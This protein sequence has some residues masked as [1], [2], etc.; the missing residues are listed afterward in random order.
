MR[1]FPLLRLCFSALALV[2]FLP[3]ASK[4]QDL[5][6]N[7]LMA[8]GQNVIVD[9]EG[10]FRDWIEIHN[11]GAN[12]VNLAG[13]RLTD[14]PDKLAK[15]TFPPQIVPAGGYLVVFASGKNRAQ[16]GSELHTNFSLKSGGEY[17]A[18]VR[19][20]GSLAH[21]V[22]YPVQIPDVSYEPAGERLFGTPTPRAA[23]TT[24]PLAI[25]TAPSFS[26]P[27][28]FQDGPFLMKLETPTAGA[29]IR[30][31]T[32]G[33]EPTETTGTRYTG[34]VLIMKTAVI[35]ACAFAAGSQPSPVVTRTYLFV[36]DVVKQSLD[37]KAPKDWPKKWGM[38]RVDYGLDP[39]IA[40]RAPYKKTLGDDLRTIPSLS[41]V[42]DLEG[43]FDPFE[44]IYANPQQKGREWERPMSL[45]LIEP[46]G[47]GGFQVNAGLRIRGG[48]S[49]DPG[50][51]KHSFR[52]LMRK[53]YGAPELKYPLFGPE[54]AQS[55][56]RFDIRCEQLVAWHYF[57]DPQADFLRDIFGRET[58]GALGQPYKRGD[59]HHLYINGQYWGLYQTDERITGEWGAE[60]FGGDEDDYDVVKYDAESSYG[61]GFTDGTLGTWRRLFEAGVRGFADDADYFA[62]QGLNPD[63]SRNR[64]QERLLDVDNLIDYMLAGIFITVDD[65]PPAFGTPN[66]WCAMRSRKEDFGF[67]FFA[68]DWEISMRDHT[69]D[70]VGPAPERSPFDEYATPESVNAWHY[71]QALRSNAEFRLRV[72]DHVQRHFFHGGPLTV[73][74]AQARWR[75]RM[76]EIDRAVVG[77]SARWGDARREGIHPWKRAFDFAAAWRE[78]LQPQ[79][80]K[81][82]DIIIID[83]PPRPDPGP[84]PQGPKKKPKPFTR[85]DW[86]AAANDRVLDGFLAGRSSVMLQHLRDGGLF[87]AVPAPEV[88][89]YG[90]ALPPGGLVTLTVEG[91]FA[92]AE[93]YYTID[94][95]DPRRIGGAVAGN[96]RR[97]TAPFA[98]AKSS[99]VKA[100]ARAGAEWSPLTEVQFT[101]GPDFRMLK[102]TEIFYHAPGSGSLA[103]DAEFLELKNTGNV[104]LDLTGARFTAGIDFIFPEGSIIAPGQFFV[105]A[106]SGAAFGSRY[107]GVVPNGIYGG[108]LNDDGETLTLVHANGARIFSINFHDE[109]PWPLAAADGFGFS[110]V[111]ANDRDPDRPA[112]W[113]ASA[114]AGGSPGSDD[115]APAAFPQVVVNELLTRPAA[116]QQKAVELLNTGTAPVDISG[117]WLTNDLAQPRKFR[118]PAGT[119]LQSRSCILFTAGQFG[120]ALDLPATGGAV[121]LVSADANGALTGYVHGL[122][123]SGSREGMSFGR[124][125]NSAGDER[126]PTLWVTSLGSVGKEQPLPPAIRINELHYFPAA[127]EEEF[128]ELQSSGE[129]SVPLAGAAI[130]GFGYVFPDGA[131]I[132][133]GDV[134]LVT[135]IEPQLFRTK[136]EIPASVQVFGPAAGVL[137]DDGER[138]ELRMP[139]TIDGV[140]TTYVA[141]SVRYDDQRPWATGAAGFGASLQRVR[142]MNYADE[143]QH[144]IAGRPTPG[145]VNNVNSPPRVQLVSPADGTTIVP[146]RT[147]DFTAE[148]SDLDGEIAKV[149]FLVDNVVVGEALPPSYRF[150]WHPTPGLHDLTARATDNEGGVSQ[151]GVITIDVDAPEFGS[152]LG[153][154]GEYFS[155]PELSG[156]AAQTR[157][158]ARIAFDWAERPPLPDFPRSGY[159]VRWTGAVLPK[160]SGDYVI[161]L[162]TSG[163]V[164]LYVNDEL[165][166]DQWDEPAGGRLTE[167]PVPVTF[168]GGELTSIRLEYAERDGFGNIALFWAEP[169]SYETMPLIQNQLY[170][171]TQDPDQ[172]GMVSFSEL[173]ARP[174]GRLFRTQLQAVNGAR[175]YLW[176]IIGDG[177]PAGVALTSGGVL[178]GTP[179]AAGVYQ[180]FVRVSDNVGHS[181]EKLLTLQV[182]DDAPKPLRPQLKITAPKQGE[183]FGGGVLTFTGTASAA[184]GLAELRYSVNGGPWHGFDAKQNWMVRLDDARGLQPGRNEVRFVA[185]DA[186]GRVSNAAQREIRRTVPAPLIVRVEGAGTVTPSFLGETQRVL[187]AEYTI[188]AKPQP[189]HLLQEWRGANGSEPKLRFMMSEGLEITAVFVPN[190]FADLS[191]SYVALLKGEVDEHRTRGAVM[192]TLT[193]TGSFTGTLDFGGKRHRFSGALGV[194]GGAFVQVLSGRKQFMGLYLQMNLDA[195]TIEAQAS[196]SQGEEYNQGSG[197]AARAGFDA[198]TGPNPFAHLYTMSISPLELRRDAEEPPPTTPEGHGYASLRIHADG[199]ARFAG[200]MSDGTLLKAGGLQRRDGQL[201]LYAPLY[202]SRGSLSGELQFGGRRDF[203]RGSGD[204]F[205]SRPGSN[206]AEG[207]DVPLESR[208]SPYTPPATGEP[209]ISISSGVLRIEGG[210][211]LEAISKRADVDAAGNLVFKPDEP[212][213]V[214]LKIDRASGL[215]TGSFLHPELGSRAIKGVVHQQGNR[216]L[217]YFPG[218]TTS[219]A[220]EVTQPP[221]Q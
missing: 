173:P 97:Y 130:S 85:T 210:D 138:V 197:I 89:P 143:P 133:P 109:A 141:D 9:E 156:E 105:L 165:V 76:E 176:A 200:R 4:A 221:A 131:E 196:F 35:R 81:A 30:F 162:R 71:W 172:L 11:P 80:V 72:A 119:V 104:P 203:G 62:V 205:W 47:G 54:G 90:G 42:M 160:V 204:L 3:C 53:E 115:A 34:P 7:E 103:E 139:I 82:D 88:A 206:E 167:I 83:P 92:G 169:G 12:A 142:T 179:T 211:L 192:L 124:I 1:S 121:W 127:G 32:D 78:G 26:P 148:A 39:R 214:R 213:K 174:V 101:P 95:S 161:F 18:L 135:T 112:S 184:R 116:G 28:G 40:D 52:V 65:S 63:G 6:I 122:T 215:V 15:W 107:P 157:N 136:Y 23:N 149:E 36:D 8:A 168:I 132:A 182:T 158:D 100:R 126:F 212:D 79:P 45:E 177:A 33:T 56:A 153:L 209:A 117:W 84:G 2:L 201:V 186:E 44:G 189:G 188:E 166:A 77:E 151:S 185:V 123:F 219:G 110:I 137:Q 134:V 94:G 146:P 21:A 118:I 48:A 5:A 24:E 25:A 198:A 29:V 207:L 181:A 147:I 67:R 220:V 180:F 128:V 191:G 102:L 140:N 58:Q 125:L 19:P 22:T 194:E 129:T 159:S 75:R 183:S 120:A 93:I 14:S 64:A 202:K 16:A 155:N 70:R 66:N 195:G 111:P 187:G 199:Q 218:N 144:W 175:P 178:S 190:P 73:E 46:Q 43:L 31:T 96:A 114:L 217:G 13:W 51:P 20:D 59:F 50:N 216:V 41:I 27:R 17:L 152:G 99:T 55:T 193:R 171:P 74:A 150:S 164:R 170:L 163:G 106:R 60:Y 49:R 69:E 57:V 38:N 87:P 113:R 145:T 208:A 37:G 10:A 86:F 91:E 98:L 108:R 68:H 61:T 154:F